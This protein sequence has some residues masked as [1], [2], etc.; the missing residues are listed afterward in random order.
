MIMKVGGMKGCLMMAAERQ[1]TL[2][3]PVPDMAKTLSQTSQIA[4]KN[5]RLSMSTDSL[6]LSM[7]RY[8]GEA[9]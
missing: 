8:L 7:G 4:G 5:C 3:R 1:I 6:T 2:C 9:H